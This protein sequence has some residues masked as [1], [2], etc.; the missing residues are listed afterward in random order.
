MMYPR[1]LAFESSCDETAV[2]CYDTPSGKIIHKMHSQV[3]LH[4]LYGGV[5]PELASRDHIRHILPLTQSAI[6]EA[7]WQW[8]DISLVA[9]TAGPGLAG[10]LMVA[11]SFA[12]GLALSLNIPIVPLHHL[13]GHLLSPRLSATPPP[14]PYIALLVSGGHSQFYQVSGM[15]QY[16]LLGESVDDAVGEAFDKSAKLLGLPYPGGQY[17]EALAKDAQGAR[18]KIQ[19]LIA[20]ASDD[21]IAPT[22]NPHLTRKLPRPLLHSPDLQMSFSGL[23]TAVWHWI[24]EVPSGYESLLYPIIADEFQRAIIEVLVT[25]AKKAR[26][27]TGINTL[28][29]C[30]G[31]AKNQALMNGLSHAFALGLSPTTPQSLFITPPEYCTDNAAMMAL[32]AVAQSHRAK[33]AGGF[34]VYPHWALSQAV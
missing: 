28:A 20:R 19:A 15:G 18:E 9:Y 16:Q 25:K 27:Q 29:L 5:V 4:A 14:F 22:L 10:S 1:I 24:R 2:A 30:G 17:L 32:S 26:A 7:G 6:A 11:A 31:V 34:S 3:A 12:E 23:K 8:S 21:P 33:T 13:E